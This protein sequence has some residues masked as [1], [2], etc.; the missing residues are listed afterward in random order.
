[1]PFFAIKPLLPQRHGVTEKSLS[2]YL[3]TCLA[4][5]SANGVIASE[6][7]FKGFSVA[8]CL[9]GE[10][11]LSLAI[12]SVSLSAHAETPPATTALPTNG[13]VVAGTAS[14]STDVSNASA[15]VLNV[16]QAS[17]RAV[18]NWQKF[19]VGADA[20]VNFNQPNAQASTLNRIS[21]PNPS[22]VFGKINAPGEVVLVN[23]AGVYFAPSASLDVGAVVATSH[24]IND[25]D[26]MAGRANFDRNGA[27]GKVINEGNIKT[28]LAGYVALLAPEVRNS[29]VI[30][31]QMGTVVMASG[32]RITLNFDP[33]RHLS[34]ITTT[35][36]AIA[37]LI[38]NRNAVR[39]PGGLIIL[40]ARAVNSLTSAVIKQ[41][42]TLS[43]SAD[44]NTLIKK[45]GR[46]MLSAGTVNLS[47]GSR[48]VARGETG[49]GSV[50]IVASKTAT[51]E[52]GAKVSVSA[53]GNG[54]GGTITIHSEEKTTIHGSLSAQGGNV[55]GNGGT[56]STTANATSNGNV[57]IGASAEV[58]A[59]VRG[60][61]GQVGTWNV[62]AANLDIT[63]TNAPVITAALNRANVNVNAQA[64]NTVVQQ[65]V[66]I[67]KSTPSLTSLTLAASDS[68]IVR[69]KILSSALSPIVLQIISENAVELSQSAALQA[70]QVVVRAP[71]I[72]ASGDYFAYFWQNG[73]GALPLIS[74]MAGRIT[75][76]GSLRAGS[77][78]RAGK[79]SVLGENGVDLQ[80][81]SLIANGDDGGEVSVIS[82]LGSVNLT[83]SYIQ[84]NG[85]EGRGGAI[86]VAGLLDVAVTGATLEAT[87]TTQ[88]GQ[89]SL[90]SYSG[91]INFLNSIIQT[92]GG[93]GLGGTIGFDASRSLSINGQLSANSQSATAGR[94]TLEA[95][96]I[97]LDTQANLQATG[98]T[99]GGTILVGGDW[100]GSGTL[101]QASTVTMHQGARID[102]SATQYGNGGKVVLWSA[103]ENPNS[104]T[105]V[106][107]SIFANAGSVGGNGG[108]I[109]TSGHQ[110]DITGVTGSASAVHGLA[111]EWLLD[112]GSITIASGSGTNTNCSFS[113]GTCVASGTS[114]VYEAN[115]EALLN[116]GTSVTLSTGTGAN[117]DI[118][119]NAEINKTAGGNATLTLKASNQVIQ[120]FNIISTVG[121]LNVILWAES[122]WGTMVGVES[123]GVT[124]NGGH[125]WIGGGGGSAVWNGLTVG[126]GVSHASASANANGVEIGG[127]I[128]TNGGSIYIAADEGHRLSNGGIVAFGDY[129]T[130]NAGTGNI[131]LMTEDHKF[132]DRSA[133]FQLILV[134]TGVLTIAPP[135]AN[136]NW[137]ADFI[138]SG[139]TTSF[140]AY[141][142]CTEVV[143][144]QYVANGLVIDRYNYYLGGL[145]L[146]TYAGT[147]VV[148][149]T[150]YTPVNY[151]NISVE[152]AINVT[153]PITLYTQPSNAG[154]V[155]F[156]RNLS[157]SDTTLGNIVITGLQT[158][159]LAD[160]A[161][162]SGRNLTVTN[163]LY[164]YFSGI[165]SGAASFT[166]A[167][168][169]ELIMMGLN[170]YT[171][172]TTISAG[173]LSFRN[174]AP[175]LTSSSFVGPGNL[176]IEPGGTSFTSA[177]T[178][179]ETL[180][181]ATNTKLGGL[182]LGK[183]GNTANITSSVAVNVAGSIAIYGGNIS[184]TGAMTAS[185]TLSL[186]TSGAVTQSAVVTASSLLLGGTGSV[187]LTN[188][189]NSISSLAT[190]TGIGAL[191]LI[192][193]GNLSI[194]S[195]TLGAS[196]YNGLNSTGII[197]V[198][199]TGNLTI[200][201]NVATSSTSAT[202]SAP[203][204]LLAAGATS[205]IGS[206]TYNIILSGSPTF[207]IGAGG[208]ADFYSGEVNASTGLSSY[209]DS[210]SAKTYTY[211]ADI[212]TQPTAAGYN[213]IYRG[214][215]PAVYLTIVDSQTGTYGSAYALSFWYSTSPTLYGVTYVPSVLS[216]FNTVQTYTAGQSSITINANGLTGT[217]ALSTALTSTLAASTY[218]L[219]LTPTLALSGSSTVFNA[220]NAK[221]FTMNPKALNFTVAKVYDGN[222]SFSN[223]NTYTLTGMVNNEIAP[224]ISAGTAS[225]A[226]A[227]V[228]SASPATSFSSN[229]LALSDANYTL[230]GGVVSA[231]IS[232]LAS[233]TYT[234][235]SGGLWSSGANW[236]VTGG[237]ATGV[238]PT[239]GNVATVIIPSGKTINYSNAM[240]GLTPSAAVTISNNGLLSFSNSS[241]VILPALISG[242]GA[243][244]LAGSAPLVYTAS[245]TYTG[246]TTIN[247]GAT[248]KLGAAGVMV[249]SATLVIAGTLNMAGYSAAVGSITGAGTITSSASGNLSLTVGAN[250]T[251]TEFSGLLA[252][253]LATSLALIK[254]GGGR[255]TLSGAN[256][257]TGSTT[258]N[259]G[260]LTVSSTGR[261]GN[262]ANPLS[263]ASATLDL[264]R[265][266]TVGSLSMTSASSA[267][268]NSSG[269]ASLVVS[270]TSSLGG[271]IS[272]VG[273]QTYSGAVTL[274]ADTTLSASAA[275]VNLNG[276]VDGAHALTVSSTGNSSLSGVVGGSVPLASLSFSS[277]ADLLVGDIASSGDISLNAV[278][279]FTIASAKTIT[280]SGGNIVIDPLRFVNYGN[281]TASG[282]WQVWSTNPDPFNSDPTIG[283]VVGNLV[284]D[285]KQYNATFGVTTVLGTGNGFLYTYAP[286]VTASLVGSISKV[287]DGSDSLSLTSANYALSGEVAGDSVVISNPTTGS[288]SS[289]GTGV[290]VN[291]VGTGKTVQANGVAISSASNGSITVYGYALSSGSLSSSSGEITKATA[292]V[293]AVKTD[294]GGVDLSNAQVTLSG[295]TV[296]GNT[297]VLTYTGTATTANSS[298]T[299]SN[300]YVMTGN[301]VLAD[302]GTGSTIGL[303]ANYNLPGS[304]YSAVNNYATVN[305]SPTA[306][307]GSEVAGSILATEDEEDDRK[308]AKRDRRRTAGGRCFP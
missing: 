59:G 224:T 217:I 236:T 193:T 303:A 20:T 117:Y 254:I 86:S 174:N 99:G 170:T 210:Q 189:S 294:D 279:T 237:S 97:L 274:A 154:S 221:D 25:D 143:S 7:F 140:N 129:R 194:G 11:V 242:S 259:A 269:V 249:N 17:Q 300:N 185:S 252:N 186:F 131:S 178:F 85:G 114:T 102:A 188:A 90:I 153:G 18:V 144:G 26:Y 139:T 37:S 120:N 172:I 244:T 108:Q 156:I 260:T 58:K 8:L 68:V 275:V 72:S 250:G 220:G 74:F 232:Q 27:T 141:M 33:S 89:V 296:G 281:L 298:A 103:I 301:M 229:T 187:S 305:A 71:I 238:T 113:A 142:Y 12:L 196:T 151:R 95:D 287:Y 57:E 122:D 60:A 285:Y 30:V 257:Y 75:L 42:G 84:T 218:S 283:D 39:A 34:S 247:N 24:S 138:W 183:S 198:K 137:V 3:S 203:A 38:E 23:Q 184:I 157:T 280:A 132:I 127:N 240:A 288:Y 266:L 104:L 40:S 92:N 231:S 81:A 6:R 46:I 202:A 55:A 271:S 248:L 166:K 195:I 29:G 200:L 163:T 135:N 243:V 160:V 179:N 204:L 273:M 292:K 152:I 45:G 19:D 128:T 169:G 110:L 94:I 165:V 253:G 235:A 106:H 119:V 80:N 209:V 82:S 63:A 149:D 66:V 41:S 145:S 192:N 261:L 96:H 182:T 234:G 205:S 126:D 291:D 177:Y 245:N 277:S 107:G 130:L 180:S 79:I 77:N 121:K 173:T 93:S 255:L 36:S 51:V 206:V 264:Q 125:V 308:G 4:K 246:I 13:Q 162:A 158:T 123:G 28:S 290:G 14:I 270:G 124:T 256:T 147:G 299:S 199:T 2:V 181:S 15:P 53:T 239:L 191:S 112:P 150:P 201:Q 216:A 116:A 136:N 175:S 52:A 16:N 215:Q 268:T 225:I 73:G 146:G 251:T 190:A 258:I 101:R 282:Y 297:Q 48:T 35:P 83:N 171:G 10:A 197:S 164:S 212:S 214:S 47:T 5:L 211:G 155:S 111:G 223:A 168:S 69:G 230:T 278:G 276:T 98:A 159:G 44:G 105:A 61:T 62:S 233:V 306:S 302:G 87:G 91:D 286:T 32:E 118:T 78:G 267:I 307:M 21:D 304:A 76:A 208:I 228:N 262:S 100:Q 289:A 1:M 272:T 219:T 241:E 167:G 161:L 43:A 227:N 222:A 213:V 148:G 265:A 70:T 133:P 284:P 109:E 49:G 207:S 134:T 67:Q 176:V 293:V 263:L 65:D 88:G 56:I 31:A 9:C 50:D 295:V 54:N 226:S 22:K 115:I 64:G